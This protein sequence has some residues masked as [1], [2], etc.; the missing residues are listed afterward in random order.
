MVRSFSLSLAAA[1]IV[2]ELL[3]VN[4]RLFPFEI[5]SVGEFQVDRQRITRA[6]IADLAKRGLVGVNGFD[7]DLECAM[8]TLSD[9]VIA[10]AVMGTVEKNQE[11]YARASATKD[12]GVLAVKEKQSMRFELIRPTAL[13]LTLVGLLPKAQAGPGQSVTIR[14]PAPAR[15]RRDDGEQTVFGEQVRATT[16]QQLRAAASY[17][18][19][20]RTGTGFFAVSGRDR[21]GR[22]VR[23]GGLTWL[24][25]DAGR[26][27]TLSR[28]PD[29]DG[30]ITGTFSPADTSRLT[31]QLG[32][33]IESVA[34]N[35]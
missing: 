20:P 31:H 26:Y 33:M 28:P 22:E 35:R 27:L 11:I 34:P 18:S 32:E 25:T 16:E 4:I 21:H 17:L 2:A 19:R 7:P 15:H 23:A 5:P 24:D 10:V 3:G 6:V 12:T 9:Y 1:D 14:R 29:E 13:A 30:V 8:R